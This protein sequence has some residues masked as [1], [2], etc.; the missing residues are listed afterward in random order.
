M[1]AARTL[2]VTVV[3]HAGLLPLASGEE[4]AFTVRREVTLEPA[5]ATVAAA[6]AGA[7]ISRGEVGVVTVGGSLVE[8]TYPLGDGAQVHLYPHFGG[9]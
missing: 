3:A 9:G 2:S 7:G 8:D 6:I 5:G 4:P 1:A